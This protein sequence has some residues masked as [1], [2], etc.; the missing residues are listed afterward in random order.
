MKYG[1]RKPSVKSSI[2]A[3][4][5][6]KVNRALK[7][8]VNPLY[9]KSGMG[10]IRDPKKALYN[11]VYSKTTFGLS[12]IHTSSSGKSTSP[13]P[14]AGNYP[15]DIPSQVPPHS[16]KLYR[17][18]GNIS[19]VFSII[20][21]LI[22]IPSLFASLFSI[23][24]ILIGLFLLYLGINCRRIARNIDSGNL[25]DYNPNI[26]EESSGDIL[27]AIGC[28][29]SLIWALIRLLFWVAILAGIIWFVVTVIRM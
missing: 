1:M 8:S 12:D 9:G 5:T 10:M 18:C 23:V 4:T 22:G 13:I 25:P 11:K 27:S 2:S 29:F 21:L 6:G 7:K 28:F 14:D 17:V 3:R 15:Q 19:I 24:I 16:S 20:A 26:P